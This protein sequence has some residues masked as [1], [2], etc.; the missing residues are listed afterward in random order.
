[1][2]EEFYPRIRH[3]LSPAEAANIALRHLR[4]RVTISTAANLPHDVP[5]IWSR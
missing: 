4:E 1:L 5:E 2:W 3:E